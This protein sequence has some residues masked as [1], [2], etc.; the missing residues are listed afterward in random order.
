MKDI[1][2]SLEAR[3]NHLLRLQKLKKEKVLFKIYKLTPLQK[4]VLNDFG[5]IPAQKIA[6]NLGVNRSLIYATAEKFKKLLTKDEIN[7]M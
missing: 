5:R 2:G 1:I 4:K 7:K 6:D 3:R